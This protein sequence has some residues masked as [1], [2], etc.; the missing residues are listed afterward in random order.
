MSHENVDVVRKLVWDGVDAVPLIRDDTTWTRWRA[1]IEAIFAPDC[2]FAWIGLGLRTEATGLDE[3]RQ[4]WLDW[5]EPWES[6]R[7]DVERIFPVGDKV[8]LMARHHGRMAGTKHQVEAMVAGV[9]LVRDGKLA[10]AD[11]DSDRAEALAAV[12]LR[13]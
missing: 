4:V 2:A 11:F 8:V 5:F 10:R 1:E 6:M 12:G 9:Y 7:A 3:A 13:E